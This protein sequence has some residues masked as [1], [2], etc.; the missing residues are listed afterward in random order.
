[1]ASQ[2]NILE[3]VLV[4]ADVW[5]VTVHIIQPDLPVVDDQARL[6]PAYLTDTA[7]D[8]H[9]LV[10]VCL[11]CPLPGRALI[12]LLLVHILDPSRNKHKEKPVHLCP[13]S[14]ATN[15]A[16]LYVPFHAMFM[17]TQILPKSSDFPKWNKGNKKNDSLIV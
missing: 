7:I 11:P 15:I 10:Y 13:A 1:M 12:E 14:Y 4:Q 2:T 9:A 5:V 17:A 6:F 8:G 16:P 3:V